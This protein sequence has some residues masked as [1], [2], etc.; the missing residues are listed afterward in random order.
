MYAGFKNQQA[1]HRTWTLGPLGPCIPSQCTTKVP[2]L[3]RTFFPS[4]WTD[5]Q[6]REGLARPPC[7]DLSPNPHATFQRSVRRWVCPV[8]P[9]LQRRTPR[10]SW[11]GSCL[12]FRSG[13]ARPITS[14]RSL[15]HRG[16]LP[17]IRG[18]PSRLLPPSEPLVESLSSS[19]TTSLASGPRKLHA[20]SGVTGS[21]ARLPCFVQCF[22]CF[23]LI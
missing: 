12:P 4:I 2:L 13:L 1:A 16:P 3:A 20:F 6:R 15:R 23:V 9:G 21:S 19:G 22:H 14:L 11:D 10:G 7:R 5:H 18:R 17:P 8:H